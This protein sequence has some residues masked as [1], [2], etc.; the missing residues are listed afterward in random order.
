MKLDT[1]IFKSYD[2]RGIYPEQIS[3]E[4]IQEVVQAVLHFYQIRI[5]RPNIS[6]VVGH[7]MR[8]S[9]PNLYPRL[10]DALVKGGAEVIDIGLSSTPTYYFAV[11]HLKTDA[12]IILTASHNP[13]QYTGMKLVIREGDKIIKI[14]GDTGMKDI[15]EFA[16][17]GISVNESG[18]SIRIESGLVE[19]E[20]E[21]AESVA[22]MHGIKPL[23]VVA[24][25]A[26]A[27]AITYIKPLFEKLP[28]TLILMNEEL[29]GS[30]PVHQPDPL[31]FE[32]YKALYQRVIDEKAD[33]G[34]AP[35]G[36]GDRVFFVDEKG[37]M[38]PGSMIT[39]LVAREL[40]KTNPGATIL[41]DI[42]Y[43]MTPKKI[44]EEN[45]GKSE[46]TRVG[47]AFITKQIHDTGA[48][49][50]GESSGHMFLKATG[51][52]ESQVAIILIV[53]KALSDSGKSMSQ[54]ILDLRRSYESGEFNFITDKDE[55]IIESLKNHYSDA[56]MSTLDGITIEYPEWR[57]NVRTSNT[58]PLLRLNLEA[59]TKDNME[60]RIKEVKTY[61]ESLGAKIHHA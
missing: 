39:A 14:G 49:F 59:D 27:M 37:G 30:F 22:T 41:Y 38:I 10:I 16:E 40:L 45:G 2:I 44:I 58:E 15:M 19:A 7:D 23:K 1:S 25:T 53:L 17:Q 51:G 5:G 61:I 34:I 3:E 6:I 4:N 8:M 47:H 28:C 12:G 24:D 20:I 56:K 43:T 21:N 9:V 35:D 26:N 55:S 13:S 18:G 48:I 42:R 32:N 57:F 11:L 33:L 52:A 54:L 50:G 29:D 31:V 46:I 60:R 36:D